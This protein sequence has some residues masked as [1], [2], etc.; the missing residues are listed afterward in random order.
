LFDQHHNQ[1]PIVFLVPLVCV[2]DTLTICNDFHRGVDIHGNIAD[3]VLAVIL[4]W[5]NQTCYGI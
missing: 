4:S 1:L 5:S 2:F 3:P